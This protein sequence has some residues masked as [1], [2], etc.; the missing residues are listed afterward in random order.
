M[1]VDRFVRMFGLVA[2]LAGCAM[3][4]APDDAPPSD[5]DAGSATRSAP[6]AGRTAD[7][8]STPDA[9]AAADAG[10]TPDAGAIP[11]PADAV[12]GDYAIDGTWDLSSPL[13][14]DR[15]LGVVASELFVEEA[16]GASGVPSSLEGAAEDAL[17]AAIGDR[18]AGYVDARAPAELAPG[19]PL[20]TAL[21]ALS[22][23]VHYESALSLSV[24]GDALDG[25][26]TFERIYVVHE[27]RDYDLPLSSAS[28]AGAS[29]EASWS[30]S[31]DGAALEVDPHLVEIRYGLLL[32]WLADGVLGVDAAAIAG[33]AASALVCAPL[34]DGILDG[35]TELAIDVGFYTSRIPRSALL[36]ACEEAA[37]TIE[38]RA[39]GLFSLDTPIEIGGTVDVQSGTA[40]ALE[41]R[42]GPD[43]GGHVLIGPH[44]LSPPVAATFVGTP[45]T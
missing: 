28:S 12:D 37:A 3:E 42:S 27:G 26:E 43:H 1:V 23:R 6:D 40:G 38:A 32:V 41:L 4:A 39:L 18:L 20:M 11:D 7:A 24:G 22:A 29:V 13:G 44:A 45:A 8:G 9:H 19:S 30:G 16:V 15:T 14:G 21:G 36:D 5:A 10:A 33:R 31:V 25:A 2:S 35:H 17:E 34:V